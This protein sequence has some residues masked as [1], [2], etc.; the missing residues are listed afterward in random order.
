MEEVFSQRFY[1]VHLKFYLSIYIYIFLYPSFSNTYNYSWHCSHNM[2]IKNNLLWFC[3]RKIPEHCSNNMFAKPEFISRTL[4]IIYFIPF[5]FFLFFFFF[6]FFFYISNVIPFSIFPSKN[7]SPLPSIP[8]FQHTYSQFLAQAFPKLGHRNFTR[9]SVSP[10]I[11]D[12]LVHPLLHMQ[13]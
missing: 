2:L 5:F 11:D 7:P 9:T 10:P 6:F 12:I 1:I 3:H 4:Q 8:A 13:L